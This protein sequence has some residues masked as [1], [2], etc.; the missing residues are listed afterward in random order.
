MAKE[1]WKKCL[2]CKVFTDSDEKYCPQYG[3]REGHELKEVWL[4]PEEILNLNSQRRIFTKYIAALEERASKQK[5][6]A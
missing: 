2:E 4:R 6:P 3:K 5:R 1:K